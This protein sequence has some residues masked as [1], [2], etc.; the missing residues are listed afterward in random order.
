MDIMD[1]LKFVPVLSI[2]FVIITWYVVYN[3]AIKIASRSETKSMNDELFKI[4]HKVND[5]AISFWSIQVEV[6]PNELSL[7]RINISSELN[8]LLSYNK[9]LSNRGVCLTPEVLAD[10][11]DAVTLDCEVKLSTVLTDSEV[12]EK[13]NIIISSGLDM[14]ME[15]Y[16]Q[17][18]NTYKFIPSKSFLSVLFSLMINYDK[19]LIAELDEMYFFRPK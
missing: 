15:L 2:I 8:K 7:Y 12:E 9:L 3:N 17:Y 18:E 4:I 11:N 5:L 6:K 10:Y 19:K 1:T 13:L 16:K 14:Q